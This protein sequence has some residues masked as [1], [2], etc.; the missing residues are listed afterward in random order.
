M[1]RTDDTQDAHL[2][3]Q[4]KNSSYGRTGQMPR[5]TADEIEQ[6]VVVAEEH[7]PEATRRT[8]QRRA[9]ARAALTPLVESSEHQAQ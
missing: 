7:I 3:H 9:D 5:P 4:V 6:G 2:E 8:L 1:S